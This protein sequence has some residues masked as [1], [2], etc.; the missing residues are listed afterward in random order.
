[1]E[2]RG[3]AKGY[4]GEEGIKQVQAFFEA[5]HSSHFA[6]M[7]NDDKNLDENSKILNQAGFKRKIKITNPDGPGTESWEFFVFTKMF[8]DE[9]C[10]GFDFRIVLKELADRG[11][12]LRGN[13]R[14]FLKEQRLPI[15]KKK[16][17][18]FTSG[19]LTGG[20]E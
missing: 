9:I 6:I 20:D 10:K 8:H 4:E 5:H 15:G 14:H 13:G 19:I 12:L 7:T 2:E 18:H 17:Y 11:F 3:N 16:I 1:M